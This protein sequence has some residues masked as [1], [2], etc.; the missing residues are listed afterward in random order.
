MG[1]LAVLNAVLMA[2]SVNVLLMTAYFIIFLNTGLDVYE[3]SLLAP[4]VVSASNVLGRFNLPVG[5]VMLSNELRKASVIKLNRDYLIQS[6]RF[7]AVRNISIEFNLGGALVP[8]I[9]SSS[10]LI[11]YVASYGITALSAILVLI[12]FSTLLINR[13]SVVIKGLGLAVPVTIAS[14][15]I[16]SL[17]LVFETIVGGYEPLGTG[18]SYLVAY[19]SIL[20]GVDL[21]NLGKI[22]LYDARKLIIGGLRVYDALSLMPATSVIIT[23]LIRT[24]IY[25]RI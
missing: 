22:T 18:V 15:M 23:H 6:L 1:G 3:A 21:M 2:V 4:L 20:L 14:L 9:I 17:C 16:S 11:N 10:L 5:G 25:P 12:T 19:A 13:I 24:V 8:F 7:R